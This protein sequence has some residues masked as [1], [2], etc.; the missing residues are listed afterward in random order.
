MCL[1]VCIFRVQIWGVNRFMLALKFFVPSW[2]FFD[3][4]G[5]FF[6]LDVQ[7]VDTA[8]W[9][10][11]LLPKPIRFWNL[12]FNPRG[13]LYLAEMSLIE[14]FAIELGLPQEPTQSENFREILRIVRHHYAM[15]SAESHLQFRFQI[16][17]RQIPPS[18]ELILFV[19]EPQGMT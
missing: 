14:R 2:R 16:R 19:S 10:A 11:V 12:F 7:Q 1:R 9:K 3:R 13:N 6:F 4:A 8:I 5:P 18:E 15:A 17:M